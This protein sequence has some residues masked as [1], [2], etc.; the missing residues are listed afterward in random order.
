MM[1]GAAC[2]SRSDPGTSAAPVEDAPCSGGPAADTALPDRHGRAAPDL[3]GTRHRP[4]RLFSRSA[5]SWLW[6]RSVWTTA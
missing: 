6:S 4:H 5:K 2:D 3:I 1:T